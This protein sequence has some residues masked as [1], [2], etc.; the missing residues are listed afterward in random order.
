MGRVSGG[1]PQAMATDDATVALTPWPTAADAVR[2]ATVALRAALGLGDNTGMEAD[3][4]DV[5][6]QRVAAAVSAKI[7][8]YSSNAPQANR[9]EALVR[10]VAWLRDTRGALPKE[11]VGPLSVERVTHS[12]AWFLHSGAASMLTRWKERRGGAC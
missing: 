4:V 7:E 10:G 3:E 2:A 5:D 9:D 11:S 8:E 6:L 12:G 1:E